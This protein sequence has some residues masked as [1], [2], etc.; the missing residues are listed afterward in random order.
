MTFYIYDSLYGRMVEYTETI[1]FGSDAGY[2]YIDVPFEARF[3]TD[4]LYVLSPQYG[5]NSYLEVRLKIND[6]YEPSTVRFTPDSLG[7]IEA[8]ISRYLQAKVTNEKIGDYD[9]ENIAETNQS[10]KFELEYRERY[11]GDSSTWVEEGNDW[12]YIYAV[13]TK[14]QGSNLSEFCNLELFNIFEKPIWWVGM[15]FDLQFWWNPKYLVLEYVVESYD[16]A[17]TLLSTNSYR[18]DDEGLGYLNSIKIN[19]DTIEALADYLEITVQEV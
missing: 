19:R 1:D 2:L 5:R 16:A 4:W 17:G 14:E 18:L 7:E 11:D 10:G 15:P 8:D 12:Y 3:A 13:R 6:V 9:S